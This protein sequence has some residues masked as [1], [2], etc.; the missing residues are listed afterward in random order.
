MTPLR[1]AI[2]A[3]SA[4]LAKLPP[5]SA[6]TLLTMTGDITLVLDSDGVI[7][8]LAFGSGDVAIEDS[9]QWVGRRWADTVTPETRGKVELMLREVAAS[10]ASH[11][12]QVNH[13]ASGGPDVPVSYSAVRL[14]ER[15]EI[16]AVG[17]D[18]RIVSSLQL[19]LVETQQA[20]ERDYWRMR[21]VET[22]YRLLFQFSSDAILVVDAATLRILDSNAAAAELLGQ[23]AEKLI[24]KAF[25]FGIA[26]GSERPVNDLLATARATGRAD[27]A[28]RLTGSAHEIALSASCF[29]Q[30]AATLFLLRFAPHHVGDREGAAHPQSQLLEL[31]ENAPDAVV[32]TDLDGVIQTA[33]RAFLD[34]AQLTSETQAAGRP[35]G[36]WLGRPGAD[37]SVFL[38]TLRKHGA[39]RLVSTTARGE[40]GATTEV[41]ISAVW[42]PHGHPPCIGFIVRDVG[43]RVAS[44]PQGARDLTRAVEQLTGLVGRMAMRDLIRD[45][46]DLVERHFIEAA[47]EL[48]EHNRTAAAEVLGLSRQSLYVKLRR[49][50]LLVPDDPAPEQAV[51]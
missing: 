46:T 50:G 26:P 14:G 29:R 8:K 37:L 23:P 41:E 9:D 6:A 1:K 43:R 2:E 42:I 18:L 5:D 36:D 10:G 51:S 17:R 32:V 15:G 47:L 20:M 35:L 3:N 45:T 44:G 33:N 22:R 34:I 31:I 19:R 27:G 40:H 49:H 12:R 21:H 30:D 28:V 11:R 24:G 25:P 39:I 13:P 4:E 7:R 16:V 48:T 38:A